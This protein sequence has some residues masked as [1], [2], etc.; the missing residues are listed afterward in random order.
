M[1]KAIK[2]LTPQKLIIYLLVTAISFLWYKLEN[3]EVKVDGKDVK[4][5]VRYD[6][7]QSKFDS[8]QALRIADE[9]DCADEIKAI[10]Q[11]EIDDLKNRVA[12]Q[13]AINSKAAKAEQKVDN[14]I[15]QTTKLTRLA[16]DIDNQNEPK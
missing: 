14:V 13:E 10:K 12:R 11:Q 15:R 4:T 5:E 1:I 6:R 9:K 8:V 2:E 16:Q 3:T 7:L